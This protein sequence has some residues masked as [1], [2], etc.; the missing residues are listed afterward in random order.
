LPAIT[1]ISGPPCT[2]GITV[3]VERLRVLA[4]HRTMPPARPAQRL[5]RRGR[6]E[7]GDADRR[8]MQAGRAP[9]RPM[10]AM[11]AMSVAPTSR[12]ISPNGVKSMAAGTR[13]RR[14]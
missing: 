10:C 7:V 8:R 11:S 14:R 1:C 4:P 5:V 6:D 3:R 13:S 9:A 2:P 12:A